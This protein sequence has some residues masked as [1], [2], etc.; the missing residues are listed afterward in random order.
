[1]GR[2]EVP[3]LVSRKRA[4]EILGTTPPHISRLITAGRMPDPI[5]IEDGHPAYLKSEIEALRD[6]LTKEKEA[7]TADG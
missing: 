1:M 7:V 4:A 6:E 2:P 5:E 3:P